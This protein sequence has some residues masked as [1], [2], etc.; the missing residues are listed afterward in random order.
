LKLCPDRVLVIADDTFPHLTLI[1]PDAAIA[2]VIELHLF[3][4]HQNNFA[5]MVDKYRFIPILIAGHGKAP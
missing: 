2:I 5:G 1:L 4:Q 3:H